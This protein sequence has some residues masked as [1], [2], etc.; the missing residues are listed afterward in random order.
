VHRKGSRD[1]TAVRVYTRCQP[2]ASKLASY[3]DLRSLVET[4]KEQEKR[5]T[6]LYLSTKVRIQT[7]Y[8]P[9]IFGQEAVLHSRECPWRLDVHTHPIRS[10]FCCFRS[11]MKWA[12]R[13]VKTDSPTYA[14]SIMWFWHGSDTGDGAETWTAASFY[15]LPKPIQMTSALRVTPFNTNTTMGMI[16]SRSAS[17]MLSKSEITI[18]RST[19]KIGSKRTF[20]NRHRIIDK[21]RDW[22]TLACESS[23]ISTKYLEISI[24]RELKGQTRVPWK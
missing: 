15:S 17:Q 18:K 2:C 3:D 7:H 8:L 16:L 19:K 12:R 20:S 14:R 6:N 21:E 11:S 4:Y 22:P 10:R 23:S 9:S 24:E 13:A 1:S 5:T